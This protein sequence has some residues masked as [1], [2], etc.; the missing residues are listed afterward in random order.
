MSD[1]KYAFVKT[2]YLENLKEKEMCQGSIKN[3]WAND[4]LEQNTSNR[5]SPPSFRHLTQ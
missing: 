1:L 3:L 4:E 2:G 5:N